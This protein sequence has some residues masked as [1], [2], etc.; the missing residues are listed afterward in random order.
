MPG[1]YW[2]AKQGAARRAGLLPRRVPA[3]PR[4]RR[5]PADAARHLQLQ[6]RLPQGRA[7]ARDAEDAAGPRAVLGGDAPVSDP[8]CL[9]LRRRA[10][11]CGR[12]CW[13][14]PARACAGSG[15][16][17]STRRAIRRSRSRPPTT[18]PRARSRSTCGR[19]RPTPPPP[20]APASATRPRS[21]FRAPIA[22][23]VGTSA[24]DVVRQVT[25]DQREQRVRI[26]SL[27]A[28]PTMV[29]FDDDNA[30]LKTLAFEQPTP[31][32]ATLLER[33][34]HLW[35]RAWAIAQLGSRPRG[36][37]R[38]RRAGAGRDAAPTTLV[39]RA[40][41]AR[42]LGGFPPAVALPALEAAARDTSAEVREAAVA[43]LGRGGR[44]AG[45]GR[46]A[47]TPGAPTR[48][49]R[50]ARTRC[51]LSSGSARAGARE[52]VLQGLETPSYRE[53]IQNAAV[54]AVVQHPDSGL[55]LALSRQLAAQPFPAIGARGAHV[56]G[57]HDC[58]RRGAAGAGRL[59][60]VGAGVDAGGAGGSARGEGRGG[61]AAG[62]GAG[63]AAAGG[64]HRRRPGD[65]PA[66]PPAELTLR[67]RAQYT[68]NGSGTRL[69]DPPD[70]RLDSPAAAAGSA[71]RGMVTIRS[72][73]AS[74][75]MAAALVPV[76]G[77]GVSGPSA[78]RPRPRARRAPARPA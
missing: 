59:A 33:H 46:R 43:A 60:S 47:E 54:T 56:A 26:D 58:A 34:P 16:S 73:P 63:A 30:V 75:A 71:S 24:G 9:R 20:T 67:R 77:S 68:G 39:T 35:Q 32:L 11:T 40:D 2:G 42:A 62:D 52:A 78:R 51:S 14:P 25:I 8:P 27:P 3:V 36:H 45:A 37:A 41:A 66:G 65:Q 21:S 50:C 55:V 29:A 5:A 15:P 44:R 6:Q 69:A 53:A 10:T 12:R 70:D 17:G 61:A 48:A 22:I 57:R 38:R 4:A 23:R 7:G 76:D 19:R 13:T 74:R 49:I 18:P 64:A 1:Q 31:W 72:I 28:A